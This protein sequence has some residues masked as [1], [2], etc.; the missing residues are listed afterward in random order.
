MV[1]RNIVHRE[2]MRTWRVHR[3]GRPSD[4]LR[5]DEIDVPEPQA[6]E[7]RLRTRTA[8]LNYNEVDGCHGRYLTVNPRCGDRH[9]LS[10]RR[11]A[12]TVLE[13]TGGRGVNLV[14]DGVGGAVTEASLR[15][16][17]ANGRLMVIGFASGI[18]AEDRP[19]VTPR[20][21]CFGSVSR[22]GVMLAYTADPRGEYPAP[23]VHITPRLVGERVRRSLEALLAK[24]RIHPVVGNV[25]SFDAVP[26]ALDLM[27]QRQ[28]TGRTIITL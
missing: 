11:F 9:R 18:E 26:T 17:A 23:G 16:L 5:L 14:F 10:Q 1:E 15:C 4:A 19:I 3:H 25:M 2:R 6:G 21:L 8:A 20:L 22:T 27:D 13:A 24:G 12:A 7:V 28:T